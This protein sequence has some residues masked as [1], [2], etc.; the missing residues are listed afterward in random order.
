MDIS[1]ELPVEIQHNIEHFPGVT[2]GAV[3]GWKNRHLDL[4]RIVYRVCFDL[5]LSVLRKVNT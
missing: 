3:T 4:S 1:H 2:L 5:L